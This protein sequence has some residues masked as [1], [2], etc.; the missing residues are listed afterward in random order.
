LAIDHVA[1][2]DHHG[3]DFGDPQAPGVGHVLVRLPETLLQRHVVQALPGE[4]GGPVG[5]GGERRGEFRF[6]P[7]G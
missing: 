5:I 6:D 1:P 7:R 3:G 4:R 2:V